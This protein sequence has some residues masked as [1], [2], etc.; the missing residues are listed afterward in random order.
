MQVI[1]ERYPQTSLYFLGAKVVQHITKYGMAASNYDLHIQLQE[2]SNVKI[3]YQTL[4]LTLN[5]LYL[6]DLIKLN[7]NNKIKPC[8]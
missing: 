7:S 6:G 3:S 2:R 5:W 4:L 8:F 1:T